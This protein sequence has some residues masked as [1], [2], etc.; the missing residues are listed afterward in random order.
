MADDQSRRHSDV[1]RRPTTGGSIEARAWRDGSHEIDE[2]A[3]SAYFTDHEQPSADDFVSDFSHLAGDDGPTGPHERVDWDD[4]DPDRFAD[5]LAS[6]FGTRESTEVAEA[7]HDE[8]AFDDEDTVDE[9]EFDLEPT[10]ATPATHRST[11]DDPTASV[12]LSTIHAA[13]DAEYDEYD[14]EV[15]RRP[16]EPGEHHDDDDLDGDDDG[17]T[18]RFV[19]SW[20]TRLGNH[21]GDKVGSLTG[22]GDRS[23]LLTRAGIAAAV[24]T[25]LGLVATVVVPTGEEDGET[26]AADLDSAIEAARATADRDDPNLESLRGAIGAGATDDEAVADTST[27]STE[28]PGLALP[29][30]DDTLAET[31]ADEDD[32][33]A[34]SADDEATTTSTE[35]DAPPT[36]DATADDTSTTATTGGSST[37]DRPAG[38]GGTTTAAPTTRPPTT[39][40]PTTAAPATTAPPAT[41]STPCNGASWDLVLDEQFNGSS[42]NTGAWEIYNN[43]GNNGYGR[44]DPNTLSV[45]N[46][47]LTITASNVNGVIHSGGMKHRHNQQYG[48]YEFRVR[49]DQ[50]LGESTSGVVLTWPASNVHPRDGENN[51]YE[52]L[53]RPGDRHEFY[54]FIHEPF[55]TKSD[56]VYIPH[57]ASATQW[58]TMVMEWTPGWIKI[59][60]DGQLIRTVDDT[61]DDLV[62]DNPHFLAIQLDA[63]KSSVNGTVRMQVDYAKVWSYRAGC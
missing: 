32:P 59:Y 18:S 56:Q 61:A 10:A 2:E 49:T 30:P 42:I 41:T 31:G 4:L 3:W 54:T 11:F 12:G 24:L 16:R 6:T 21:L 62:P 9:F 20:T 58:H 17:W 36:G 37:T 52:T 38:A 33:E 19:P 23:S 29:S 34:D 1:P 57:H 25:V 43:V 26:I 53:K 50:D 14:D 55:G 39:A 60:R 51:I 27:S 28:A 45:N 46:G 47:V 8:E 48:R 35:D 5:A 15:A 22:T 7:D 63:W 40:A 44:R 13:P